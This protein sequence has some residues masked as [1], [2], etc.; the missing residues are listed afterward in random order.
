ML[1][2]L[3]IRNLTRNPIPAFPY[4]KAL[5]A[6]LP[7]FELSLVFVGE[8]RA[9][10][11]NHALRGKD[12]VPNVLSY[13]TGTRSGEVIICP[14][15]AKKQAASYGM[16]YAKFL[17]FLFIHGCL[18]LKGM[19]HGATMEHQERLLLKRLLRNSSIPS[20]HAPKNR[21]RH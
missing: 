21:H 12:Y 2:S 3:D 18:H 8:I 13:E 6:A 10:Q 17:G 9:K 5:R 16:T 14:Q 4:A 20:T 7:G 1:S 15:V 11:M 19:P